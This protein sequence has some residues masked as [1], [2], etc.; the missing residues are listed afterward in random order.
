MVNRRLNLPFYTRTQSDDVPLQSRGVREE[1]TEDDEILLK[2]TKSPTGGWRNKWLYEVAS[3]LRVLGLQLLILPFRRWLGT[4]R[5]TPKVAVRGSR[6]AALLRSLIHL[7]PIAASLALVILT[8]QGRYLGATVTNVSYLQ[9]AAKAHEILIQAS[10][11]Y[12]IGN[13]IGR[14]L[15]SIRGV[16]FGLIFSAAKVTDVTYLWSSAF[17]GS[18][19][20][21]G[22]M[23][24]SLATVA[25]VLAAIILATGAGPSSAILMIPRVDSWPAGSTRFWVNAPAKDIWPDNLDASGLMDRDSCQH[26][27][28][29]LL[30]NDCPGSEYGQ[31]RS[32]FVLQNHTNVQKTYQS[33]FE[34]YLTGRP[35]TSASAQVTGKNS[36]RSLSIM[37]PKYM[38]VQNQEF[39]TTAAT[40]ASVP[41]AAVAD[42][43]MSMAEM[44]ILALGQTIN[45]RKTEPSMDGWMLSAMSQ[46]NDIPI[47]S[48]QLVYHL[49]EGHYNQAYITSACNTL[50]LNTTNIDSP[51]T[52]PQELA[53][54]D[55]WTQRARTADYPRYYDPHKSWYEIPN[56]TWSSILSAKGGQNDYRI[57][58]LG[59]NTPGPRNQV[60]ASNDSLLAFVIP[61]NIPDNSSYP[62]NLSVCTA[63]AGWAGSTLNV[64][65]D[66]Q[67][68]N[69]ISSSLN[70]AN[71]STTS[72]GYKW[73][74]QIITGNPQRGVGM[75]FEYPIFP[76][77]P[78]GLSQSW[79]DLLNPTIP[80]AD[81]VTQNT[82]VFNELVRASGIMPND[83][84]TIASIIS[85]MLA[86]GVSRAGFYANLTG[87]AATDGIPY[88]EDTDRRLSH[89][90]LENSDVF[91]VDEDKANEY[92]MFKKDTFAVGYSF[93]IRGTPSILAIIVLLAYCALALGYTVY[94]V[95][96]G[97]S[98]DSW[99]SVMEIAAL[100]MNSPPSE[101]LRNTG[102]GITGMGVYG[103]QATVRVLSEKGIFAESESHN[104]HDDGEERLALILDEQGSDVRSNVGLILFSGDMVL[105]T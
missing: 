81:N 40:F 86:N 91:S 45:V 98:A 7:V 100:A 94:T 84:I 64:T 68:P 105:T 79:L 5:E 23:K 77:R 82:T 50:W 103:A 48:N 51:A 96:I 18:L 38:N 12:I 8:I 27:Q 6:M 54:S 69:R 104:I 66:A 22:R 55:D 53:P 25:M 28:D 57:W 34:N 37:N 102:A 15:T 26:I 101:A 60:T 62:L 16:P 39:A 89:R 59:L 19:K 78:I 20:P 95:I 41:Q 47:N 88:P 72:A 42:A 71:Q 73:F 35:G 21:L 61:P 85:A 67:D 92:T 99:S 13:E 3:T 1:D 30:S 75:D 14:Q 2:S 31:L 10:L 93:R 9:F 65:A 80:A 49:L 76:Q 83:T 74:R 32:Y 63:S 46:W 11:T 90:W 56:V 24:S 36:L 97:V 43:L 58:W 52:I 4:T 17:A 29:P 44:W 87:T 33:Y 70:K